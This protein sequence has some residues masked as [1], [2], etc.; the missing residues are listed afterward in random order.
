PPLPLDWVVNRET[1]GNNGLV[2]EAIHLNSPVLLI[3]KSFLEK[4]PID[5]E[6]SLTR[7]YLKKGRLLEENQH[8]MVIQPNNG[9]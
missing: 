4:I 8:F 5:P 9:Q 3:Q 2:E 1:N 7:D 6:L